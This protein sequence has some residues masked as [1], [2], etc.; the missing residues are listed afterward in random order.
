M[1]NNIPEI[2]VFAHDKRQIIDPSI[3]YGY[4]FARN[5]ISRHSNE[6]LGNVESN[7]TPTNLRAN[8]RLGFFLIL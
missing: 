7:F 8:G 3:V 4:Y 2:S 5:Y 1:I 6:I